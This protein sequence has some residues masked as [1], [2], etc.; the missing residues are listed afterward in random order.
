MIILYINVAMSYIVYKF[1]KISM[2]PIQ[3]R[4]DWNFHGK[5]GGG[6]EVEGG[7]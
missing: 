2:P 7:A 6:V 3:D 5:G 4:R 1:Q